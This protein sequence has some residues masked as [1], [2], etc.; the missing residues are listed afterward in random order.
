MR[1]ARARC[2]ACVGYGCVMETM[3]IP[4]MSVRR[5]RRFTDGQPAIAAG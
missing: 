2:S 5:G 4:G 3:G 1:L